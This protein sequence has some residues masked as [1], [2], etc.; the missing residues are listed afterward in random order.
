MK[1]LQIEIVNNPENWEISDMHR[2]IVSSDKSNLY[3]AAYA[4]VER[5]LQEN[6]LPEDTDADIQA[7]VEDFLFENTK[8]DVITWD[9]DDKFQL[10]FTEIEEP[11]AILVTTSTTTSAPPILNVEAVPQESVATC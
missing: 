1:L 2:C 10:I 7:D 9:G 4:I 3:A 11:A 6:R 8:G 5:R